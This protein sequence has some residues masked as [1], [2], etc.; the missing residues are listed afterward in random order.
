MTLL[1]GVE[2]ERRVIEVL[3]QGKS[4]RDIAK[5]AHISFAEIGLIRKN[6]FGGTA[7]QTETEERREKVVSKTTK[8][9]RLIEQ[10]NPPIEVAIKLDNRSKVYV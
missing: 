2:R 6:H 1:T 9:F 10:G 5:D 4:T 8:A 7:S 3:G